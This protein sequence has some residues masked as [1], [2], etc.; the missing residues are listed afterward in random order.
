MSRTLLTSV[1]MLPDHSLAIRGLARPGVSLDGVAK[2][3]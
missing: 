3:E 1:S 2:Q